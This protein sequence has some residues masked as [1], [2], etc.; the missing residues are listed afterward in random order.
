MS[1]ERELAAIVGTP[2]VHTEPS[3]LTSYACDAYTLAQSKPRAVVLPGTADEVSGIVRLLAHQGVPWVA[4]GAGTS[5]SG[6]ATP[7]A[8]S[9][10]IHFSRMN[11]LRHIDAQNRIAEVEPGV[12]NAWITKA[13]SHWGLF[14][15]PDPSSQQACTIGGNIAENSG[16][17]HCLK[18]GVTVN[19]I[20]MAD[21][22]WPDG[23]LSRVGNLA[24]EPDSVDL[25]GLL[26][27]SEGTLGIITRA[28]VRLLP[29]PEATSTI[30]AIFEDV[31][32]ASQ[33]VSDVIAAGIIPSALEMMDQLAVSAVEKGAYHVGYPLDLGAVL[34]AEVDGTREACEEE[35]E[36]ML[37]ICR[38]HHVR[39]VKK[40]ETAEQRALW[41]ANRKTAFG[42]MGLISPRYY[43]QDGVIPRSRLPEALKAMEEIAQRHRIR[44]ANVFHAGDGNLH[45]LL[46]YND[47]DADEVRRVVEAGHEALAVCVR[48]GGSITGEHGVGL[49]KMQD[50]L[51][52][53]TPAELD[54]QRALKQAFDP[55]ALMNPGKMLPSP[56]S[57]LSEMVW[58]PGVG[59]KDQT[60]S[61]G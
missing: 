25:L 4:R 16:G 6:G 44:I 24:G 26:V 55:R 27:G 8:G 39:T 61:A 46:L 5:L 20:L 42:A 45:P 19:H 9:V 33:A 59:P 1:L 58:A 28:W 7:L 10:I 23:T 43:V 29:V 57:C 51:A 40:A 35:A 17:P 11:R 32:S 52:Q 18:Y 49:E 50:M 12:V 30:Q 13:A 36:R 53:F 15:A 47:R 54:L 34:L 2:Y 48:L 56:G 22:V 31:D 3:L 41:W 60:A 21:V 38:K 14:Y 37:E